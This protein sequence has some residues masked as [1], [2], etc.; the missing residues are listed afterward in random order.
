M[1]V[2]F[3]DWTTEHELKNLKWDFPTIPAKGD[4]VDLL[5]CLYRVKMREFVIAET[6]LPSIVKIWIERRN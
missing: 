4:W 1:T 6:Q 5:D 2:K 3:Y